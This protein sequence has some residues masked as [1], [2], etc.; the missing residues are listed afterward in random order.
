MRK[1]FIESL[2]EIAK[3]D[4]RVF[5]LTGD[6]GFMVLDD[7]INQIPDRFIN[8]GVAEQ[9]MVGIAT[10][11][12]EAGYIP[13][14]YS[15]VTFSTLR[16]YEFIRNGPLLH[17]LPV[18][19]V[20]V[21]G[22][23]EYGVNGVTHYGLEDVAVMRAQPGMTVV[24][25]ADFEQTRTALETTY[26]MKGPVYYRLGKDEKNT[27]TGLNGEFE[28]GRAQ[29]VRKGKDAVIIAMGSLS[30]EAMAAADALSK[31][32]ID[33]GLA[34]VASLQPAPA[35]DLKNIL[36]Q[37]PVALTAEAH[38]INGGLGSLVSEVAAEAGS[39]CRVVRAAVREMPRGISGSQSYLYDHYGLSAAKMAAQ[40]KTELS[41]HMAAKP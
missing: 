5:L 3:K 22:G 23:L 37:Y 6:L 20:G 11:L 40:L 7:Y 31:D 16:P 1:T 27:V 15:I 2:V 30:I 9:N 41:K 8:V 21:G 18:R 19:I 29:W 10:G 25:P 4:P 17:N 34:I 26:D 24:A 33:C 38:Y 14:V 12:A 39:R 32:G 13:F 28:P 35:E 36:S